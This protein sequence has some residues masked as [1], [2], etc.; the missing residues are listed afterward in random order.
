MKIALAQYN[1]H[2]GNLPSNVAKIKNGILRAKSEG[3]DLVLF[4][5]LSVCG[6]P[7][8]DLLQHDGFIKA[9][10]AAVKGIAHECNGIAAIIGAP[11]R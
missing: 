9:Y 10:E 2:V 5:E 6:Y 11:T 8:K 4:S 1:Y 7:P 3:A